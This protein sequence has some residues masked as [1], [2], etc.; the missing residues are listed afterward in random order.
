M[1]SL[2]CLG[3]LVRNPVDFEDMLIANRVD[4]RA[5]FLN[6]GCACHFVNV[7]EKT[8]ATFCENSHVVR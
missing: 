5:S 3:G 7:E 4:C 2:N 6:S 8:V 1:A